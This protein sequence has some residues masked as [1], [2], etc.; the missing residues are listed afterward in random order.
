MEVFVWI[1]C[2]CYN[3]MII[4]VFYLIIIWFFLFV[5][6]APKISQNL[7]ELSNLWYIFDLTMTS[8]IRSLNFSSGKSLFRSEMKINCRAVLSVLVNMW[9]IWTFSVKHFLC[10]SRICFVEKHY[11]CN[12]IDETFNGKFLQTLVIFLT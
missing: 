2:Q 10:K 11:F 4:D 3:A 5:F 12:I 8:K 9:K 1:N 6:L 7:W